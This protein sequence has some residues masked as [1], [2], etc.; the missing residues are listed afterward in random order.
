MQKFKIKPCPSLWSMMNEIISLL[1][2]MENKYKEIINN[3]S[4]ML[5]Q[6]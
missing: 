2:E 4:V 1:N 5:N 3:N 6:Y